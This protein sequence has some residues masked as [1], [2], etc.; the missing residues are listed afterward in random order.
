MLKNVGARLERCVRTQ[1]TVARLGGDEFAVLVDGV[2]DRIEAEDIARRV[3]NTLADPIRVAGRPM[4]TTASIG[5]A[6]GQAGDTA[7]D[8]LRNRTWPCTSPRATAE[9]ASACT[10]GRCT[11]RL[12]SAWSWSPGCA[13]QRFATNSSSTSS[14]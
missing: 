5:I 3:L 8:L 13:A 4:G 6:Y 9:T 7:D 12:S 11:M 1:D 10:S 14:R 2:D